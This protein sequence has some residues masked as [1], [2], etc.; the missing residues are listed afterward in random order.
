M[1]LTLLTFNVGLLN[2][3]GKRVAPAPY[4][5]ERMA[6]LAPALLDCGADVLAL[7]EI[8]DERHR[9]LLLEALAPVYPHICALGRTRN[10]GLGNGLMTLSKQ[11][12]EA[13][14]LIYQHASLDERL[15]CEKAA[16]LLRMT[17]GKT[18]VTLTNTHLTAGGAFWHPEHASMDRIR[19]LQIYQLVD[20][21]RSADTDVM[22][23]LGDLNTGPGVSQSNYARLLELGF[24]DLHAWMKPDS[25]EVTWEPRNPLN[26]N[27]PHRTSPP[28]RI[29]HVFVRAVDLRS[30]LV[31][32]LGAEIVYREPLVQ[33]RSGEVT[34]SDHYGVRA[35]L[36]LRRL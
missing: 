12:H 13:A 22:L 24:I 27:G 26:R 17:L 33:T 30:G 10:F 32:P 29:D 21:L 34:L 9:R 25:N 6:A 2:L 7:Q 18:T 5:D 8:Y 14:L 3:I 23:I 28:Q 4:V 15:F 1:D 19:D 36:R 11:P 31:E 20:A 35:R 16:H